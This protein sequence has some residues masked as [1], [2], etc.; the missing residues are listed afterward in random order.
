M[1]SIF[2]TG[3]CNTGRN[4]AISEIEKIISTFGFITD[5]N[6]FSDFSLSVSIELE[7]R[8]IDKLYEE[9]KRYMRLDDFEKLNSTS[10]LERRIFLNITFIKGTGN[11]RIEVPRVPG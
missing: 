9:L 7:E 11:L 3:Y 6:R 1:K 4:I 8:K 5:F 2:W 10:D